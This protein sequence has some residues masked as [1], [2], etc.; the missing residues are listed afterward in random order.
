MSERNK[1][2]LPFLDVI[3]SFENNCFSTSVYRKNTFKHLFTNYMSL[4]SFSYK[5]GLVKTLI[6]RAFNICSSWYHFH[7]EVVN[8]KHFL[9]KK[10]CFHL[11]LLIERFIVLLI[12]SL[13]SIKIKMK[14]Q[15]IHIFTNYR[16]SLLILQ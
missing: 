3:I 7:E 11:M 15:I 1:W 2:T 16:L 8:I 12:P 6:N 9:Q 13:L 5:I 10:H 14:L 4:T